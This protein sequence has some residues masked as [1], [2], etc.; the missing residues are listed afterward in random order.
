MKILVLDEF[1]DRYAE[2]LRQTAHDIVQATALADVSGEYDVLLAQPDLA[3][4]YLHDG[5]RTKWIQSTWAGVRPITDALPDRTVLVTGVKDVFGPQIT[6]YVFTYVLEDVRQPAAYRDNQRRRVWHQA[7]PETAAG[8]HMLVVGAGSIG[9]HVAKVARVF[10]MRVTGVSLSGATLPEFDRV[11]PVSELVAAVTDADYVVLVLPDTA[12]THRLIDADV[13]SAMR[14]HPLLIN[15]GRGSTV[16]EAALLRALDGGTVRGAV[17]DVFSTEPL[18]AEHP[19]WRTPGV[20]ITPHVAAV[21]HPAMIAKV[22]LRNLAR[23]EAGEAL[24]FTI[25]PARGY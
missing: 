15:V 20:T 23:H 19:L 1:A 3:A 16:D 14:S 7:L 17:L 10:G 5:R 24:E 13:F 9:R 21:S 4:D 2:H 12:A 18:P 6:E 25:D 8:R 11:A 22:F